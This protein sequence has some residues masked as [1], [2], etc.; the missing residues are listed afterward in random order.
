[1]ACGGV[2]HCDLWWHTYIVETIGLTCAK[3]AVG[4]RR[5]RLVSVYIEKKSLFCVLT[6]SRIVEVLGCSH[7]EITITTCVFQLMERVET[8]LREFT[9]TRARQ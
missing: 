3:R 4:F 2:G 7:P 1:M 5:A 9:D 6:T 8:S